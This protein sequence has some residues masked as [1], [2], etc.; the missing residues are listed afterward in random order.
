MMAWPS[1]FFVCVYFFYRTLSWKS[2]TCFPGPCHPSTPWNILG[3]RIYLRESDPSSAVLVTLPAE[4]RS[5]SFNLLDSNLC[6][7]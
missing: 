1:F 2:P 3:C 5:F 4:P 6:P 7:K